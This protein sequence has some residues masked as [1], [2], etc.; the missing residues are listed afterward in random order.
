MW[1]SLINALGR[2]QRR[3][4]AQLI[5]P[6]KG[7]R[8][9]MPQISYTTVR[10]D[11]HR[12]HY[13]DQQDVE[14]LLARLPHELWRRLRGVH[15]N[16][17]GR[18][19]RVLGYVNMGHREIAICAQPTRVSLTKFLAHPGA[20]LNRLRRSPTEFGA[21]RGRKWSAQAVR[22]FMLYQVFLHELGHMQVTTPDA[23]RLRRRFASETKADSFAA[24]WR[25][26]LWSTPFEH[27]DPIHNRAV[28]KELN[29]VETA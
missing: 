21:E 19:G 25:N 10:I 9:P 27:P 20:T 8:S 3:P 11:G 2:R 26:R 12:R 16:D 1:P 24:Y 7:R 18:G 14:T 28:S 6:E 22:R 23:T 5:H 4:S 13:I 17:R 15:F 29:T